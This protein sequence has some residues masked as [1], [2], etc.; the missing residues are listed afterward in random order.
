MVTVSVPIERDVTI[1]VQKTLEAE[2]IERIK[3]EEQI[4]KMFKTDENMIKLALKRILE[5]KN[6]D[7]EVLFQTEISNLL[8]TDI[9][10]VYSARSVAGKLCRQILK[11]YQE[12][13]KIDPR[14]RN[15]ELPEVTDVSDDDDEPP[16]PVRSFRSL[17]VNERRNSELFTEISSNANE[18][19]D[20]TAEPIHIASSTV[21]ETNGQEKR[22]RKAGPPMSM[23]FVDSLL[24][25][26]DTLVSS[27]D[28]TSPPASSPAPSV[29]LTPPPAT[30]PTPPRRKRGRPAKSP[31]DSLAS[32]TRGKRGRPAN[33]KSPADPQAK[34]RGRGRPKK[35]IG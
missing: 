33:V 34:K 9:R 17:F 16:E 11:R 10:K 35:N 5:I 31:K 18:I 24:P 25:S 27:I 1:D 13:C 8:Y 12:L 30:P 2:A 15:E 3:L 29:V 7:T 19:S 14:L 23:V 21:I 28:M 20:D 22:K 26:S 6:V 32:P 4:L